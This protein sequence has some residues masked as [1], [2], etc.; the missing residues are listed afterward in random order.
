MHITQSQRIETITRSLPRLRLVADAPLA[1]SLSHRV[2]SQLDRLD[3]LVV[4]FLKGYGMTA[5]R[6]SLGI[7]FFWFG[8]L[9]IVGVSSAAQLVTQTVFW[10]DASWF[11]PLLGFGECIIGLCFFYKPLVRVALILMAM[12]MIG[13][14]FPFVVLPDTTMQ[15][16]ILVP[17]MEGQYILKNIVLIAG[18]MVVGAQTR[19]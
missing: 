9:K 10:W 5:L 11:L 2:F 1:P 7:V 19:D 18:A 13:T 17:T 6:L 3:A 4:D 8:F 15:S 12:Q 14:F 16:G